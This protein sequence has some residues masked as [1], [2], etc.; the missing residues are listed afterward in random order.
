MHCGYKVVWLCCDNREYALLD[1]PGY[2]KRFRSWHSK[3]VETLLFFTGLLV[4]VDISLVVLVEGL[5]WNQASTGLYGCA[6]HPLITIKLLQGGIETRVKVK[7]PGIAQR[8]SPLSRLD[9]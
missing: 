9:S 6:P 5:G 8:K 7:L 2:Q 3:A 1:N 4:N